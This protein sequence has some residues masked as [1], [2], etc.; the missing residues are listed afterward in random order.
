MAADL[1][2]VGGLVN[3][4]LGADPMAIVEMEK[5]H[6]K[7]LM[8]QGCLRESVRV[9]GEEGLTVHVAQMTNEPGKFSLGALHFLH[10]HIKQ[11]SNHGNDPVEL[12]ETVS[13]VLFF[14]STRQFVLDSPDD[15]AQRVLSAGK[16][17]PQMYADV[18]RMFAQTAVDLETFA[19][20]IEPLL[21]ACHVVA[22]GESILTPSHQE[23]IRL[24]LKCRQLD[25]AKSLLDA[26]IFGVNPVTTGLVP[27]DFLL[28]FYYGGMAY[29]ACKE[30]ALSMDF[31][32]QCINTPADGLSSIVVEAH[33]Y[34]TLVS[35]F[36]QKGPAP[37][38]GW[39]KNNTIGGTPIA[40]STSLE[41]TNKLY[42]NLNKELLEASEG[43]AGSEKKCNTF[44]EDNVMTFTEDRTIGLVRQ[45][46]T[47]I[48]RRR[49]QRLTATYLTL[50]I[51]AIASVT[52]VVES[53][54]EPSI[55]AMIEDGSIYASVDE[56]SSMV[57][58]LEN[59]QTY[60]GK[61]S[62]ALMEERMKE[63][64][65][66]AERVANVEAKVLTDSKYIENAVMEHKRKTSQA[67]SKAD[68]SSAMDISMVMDD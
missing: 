46:Q 24:C 30:W 12:V 18:C 9:A 53:D 3:S 45:A 29:A 44:I 41:Q 22:N 10:A 4:I 65:A 23:V 2:R 21:R 66:L 55:R 20:G 37:A 28:Y 54:V 49:M 6:E 36:L 27:K 58:F 43:K 50:S 15:F 32:T 16:S 48:Y 25:V 64:A 38:Q 31:F 5:L 7:L 52:G 63:C 67:S 1:Q 47:W 57:S 14:Q 62:I 59:P 60:T 26:P 19:E 34:W 40:V 11:K 68:D 61:G 33:K 35:L 17:V 39:K 13:K 8:E 42:V 51:S 56:S